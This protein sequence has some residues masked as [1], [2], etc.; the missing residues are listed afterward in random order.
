MSV[1]DAADDIAALVDAGMT[2][3]DTIGQLAPILAEGNK[4]L[5]LESDEIADLAVKF[6]DNPDVVKNI[7]N[8]MASGK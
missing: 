7:Y 1:N 4:L 5:G 6:K 3:Q 2:N 8:M